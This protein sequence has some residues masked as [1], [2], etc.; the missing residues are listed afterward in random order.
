MFSPEIEFIESQE[1]YNLLNEGM[2][3]AKISDPYYLYLIG[4]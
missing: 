4:I 2:D 3:Y 1:L